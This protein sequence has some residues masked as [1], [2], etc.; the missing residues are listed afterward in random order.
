FGESRT[1][2]AGES[3]EE[4]SASH[5]ENRPR[6]IAARQAGRSD[7]P[8]STVAATAVGVGC[9]TLTERALRRVRQIESASMARVIVNKP[10][11]AFR[12]LHCP[13]GRIENRPYTN[14]M[15]T[16]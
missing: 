16:Q 3:A 2:S 6:R 1:W 9:K 15:C 5:R 12:M 14:S 10:S 4:R 11:V 13:F 8:D 7:H